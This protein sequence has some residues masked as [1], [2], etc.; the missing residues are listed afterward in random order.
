MSGLVPGDLHTTLYYHS[1][2]ATH[3]VSEDL[4]TLVAGCVVPPAVVALLRVGSRH[5][6]RAGAG[7]RGGGGAGVGL[8]AAAARYVRLAHK[9]FRSIA[10]HVIPAAG[11][12]TLDLHTVLVITG[13]RV[14]LAAV[15]GL[16]GPQS[17]AVSPHVTPLRRLVIQTNPGVLSAQQRVD[18][19]VLLH[20]LDLGEAVT[21]SAG[22]L[23]LGAI[24]AKL[25]RVQFVALRP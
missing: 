21:S 4:H 1:P 9:L 14:W 20:G 25:L 17:G 23:I 24:P 19:C 12:A 16:E 22:T 15:P 7:G 6:H 3:L 18:E 8:R 2:H 13:V 5:G 10:A 11:V